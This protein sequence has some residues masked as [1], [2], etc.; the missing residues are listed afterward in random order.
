MLVE[1]ALQELDLDLISTLAAPGYGRAHELVQ[2]RCHWCCC[3]AAAAA[4]VVV[5]VAV[6]FGCRC[7]TMCNVLLSL[8]SVFAFSHSLFSFPAPFPV[9][10]TSCAALVAAR[11]TFRRSLAVRR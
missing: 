6:A 1:D 8:L 4:V 7:S 2:R 5:A 9:S 11:H 10:R 3:I